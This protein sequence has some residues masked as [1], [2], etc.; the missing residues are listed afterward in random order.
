M[1]FLKFLKRAKKRENFEDLDLPPAPPTLSPETEFGAAYGGIDEKIPEFPDF[2]ELKEED[3]STELR[4]E[5][6]PELPSFPKM[7]EGPM[8]PIEVSAPPE[9]AEPMHSMPE[10][11][12]EQQEMEA[13]HE[14]TEVTPEHYPG[15]GRR[16]FGHEKRITREK[17]SVKTIYV[18]VENF[19]AMLGSINIVRSDLR[20]SEESLMK[21]ENLKASKDNSFDKIK[22]SLDDLQKKLIFI[23]KTLFKGE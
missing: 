16:L 22:S 10:Q 11:M 19:K 21:L 4:E 6:L 3:I 15:I 9:A 1:G 23:D 8:L 17:P 14:E 13:A 12:P 18:K 2:P 20:N 5:N 7:E